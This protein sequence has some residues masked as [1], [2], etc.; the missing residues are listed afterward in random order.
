M[1]V[2]FLGVNSR[3]SAVLLGK[4]SDN[5]RVYHNRQEEG[6]VDNYNSV[7]GVYYSSSNVRGRIREW[8][9]RTLLI[10]FKIEVGMK[11]GALSKW[12]SLKI[13]S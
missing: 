3:H 10:S 11:I 9:V 13:F 12:I 2:K 6:Q 8:G 1:G 4:D 7:L 5:K